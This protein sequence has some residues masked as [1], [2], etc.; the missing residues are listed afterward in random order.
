MIVKSRF[1]IVNS[2]LLI[3]N[4]HQLGFHIGPWLDLKYQSWKLFSF[5]ECIRGPAQA[6]GNNAWLNQKM[7]ATVGEKGELVIDTSR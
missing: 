6:V 2:W 5:L 4:K 3:L 1:K 7:L